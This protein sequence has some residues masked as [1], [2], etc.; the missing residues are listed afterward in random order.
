MQ[1]VQSSAEYW[2]KVINDG[3]NDGDH[4]GIFEGDSDD[5]EK[6]SEQIPTPGPTKRPATDWSGRTQAKD[7]ISVQDFFIFIF[8]VPMRMV[9]LSGNNNTVIYQK[10]SGGCISDVAENWRR[11]GRCVCMN[12]VL[13]SCSRSPNARDGNLYIRTNGSTPITTRPNLTHGRPCIRYYLK[14]MWERGGGV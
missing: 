6:D 2:L 13:D 14:D 4:Q 8:V 10:C 9:M 11:R 1:L 12:V 7:L 5:E 3:D